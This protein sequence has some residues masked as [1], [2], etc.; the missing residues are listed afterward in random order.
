MRDKKRK[1]KDWE[2]KKRDKREKVNTQMFCTKKFGFFLEY[3][4][5][6]EHLH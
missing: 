5:Y 1:E 6:I 4:N 2:K 3:L